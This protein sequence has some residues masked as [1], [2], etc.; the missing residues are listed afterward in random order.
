LVEEN[1]E[2]HSRV[3]SSVPILSVGEVRESAARWISSEAVWVIVDRLTKSA[4]FIPVMT[5]YSSEYLAR[6]YISE[7]IR[8]HGMPV[9][10]ISDQVMQF[11]SRFWRVVKHELGTRF[12][13]NIN[14][15]LRRTDRYWRICTVHV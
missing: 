10:I 8:H 2:G 7:I 3:C 4:H 14:F 13:L 9:S 1:E 12:K 5:I 6:V 11:I 15:T